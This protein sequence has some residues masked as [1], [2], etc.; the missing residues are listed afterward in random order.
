MKTYTVNT[1]EMLAE[2]KHIVPLLR[3]AGLTKEASDQSKE[4]KEIKKKVLKRSMK[5]HVGKG[6]PVPTSFGR[7]AT[8]ID[9]LKT[10]GEPPTVRSPLNS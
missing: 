6:G 5:K 2:H 9:L 8:P 7:M 3:R 10:Q 1:K 4:L